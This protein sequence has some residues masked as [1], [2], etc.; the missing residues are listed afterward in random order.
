M[1]PFSVSNA[2]KHVALKFLVPVAALLGCVIL[3]MGGL[4]AR[5]QTNAVKEHAED[6]MSLTLASSQREMALTNELISQQVTTAVQLLRSRAAQ[7]YGRPSLKGETTLQGRRV[8]DLQLGGKH[9]TNANGLPDE[10]SGITGATATI[11]AA[12]G[13]DFVRVAT[14]IRKA[15]G[16][17]AIGTVLDPAG[18]AYAEVSQGR[19]F[20]GMVDILGKPYLTAYEPIK[21]EHGRVI[22]IFYAGFAMDA[23][24]Q[25]GD[26]VA[27]TN[28]LESG[29]IAVLDKKDRIIFK[30]K[31][32]SDEQ[33]RNV[34]GAGNNGDWVTKEQSF[35]PWSYRTVVS[36]P[37]SDLSTATRHIYLSTALFMIL[38][39]GALVAAMYW[40]IEFT[41]IRP[42]SAIIETMD[43]A[44]LSTTL[45][46]HQD[47]EIGNLC[48]A[49]N[50]FLAKIRGVLISVKDVSEKVYSSSGSLSSNSERLAKGAEVQNSEAMNV[51]AALEEMSV[52]VAMVNENCQKAA[53]Q[54]QETSSL[55]HKGGELVVSTMD[56]VR[57]MA[58]SIQKVTE[59]I[60]R[61]GNSSNEIGKAAAVIDGIAD[62]T[63][64]LA[65]NAAIEAARAG[66]QG[67]GFAVV[68][69]EVRKLAERT[70]LA[71]RE[72]GAMI[73]TVQKDT[74]A[75]VEA[76]SREQQE[77]EARSAQA[78][79]AR[80]ALEN[81]IC[82]TSE[83][84]SLVRQIA[85]AAGEHSRAT[86]N[87]TLHMQQITEMARQA[88][89]A[90][91]NTAMECTGLSTDAGELQGFVAQFYVG[92]QTEAQ[93]WKGLASTRD[94]A[95]H[96][97]Q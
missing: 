13:R 31:S 56:S 68:A 38:S 2:K 7:E 33:I 95:E 49:L 78:E 74:H 86:E 61:L 64:L 3:L 45:K 25:L 96:Q 24:R 92:E 80:K 30:T 72:I 82:S 58:A 67:R 85:N 20:Y 48:N 37:K 4:A 51:K 69:D 29:W 40:M 43:H 23:L 55:A 83:V 97:L 59:V 10:V 75:A 5:K 41:V 27:H 17:R 14:S 60:T 18:A 35:R 15:N 90:A 89:S 94:F 93:D 21:E 1:K 46:S 9:I 6:Q 54:V 32:A 12:S 70:G 81:I 52:N 26:A 71:T 63:N 8:G 84:E 77:I 11:F 28:I 66:E 47:D 76:M 19:P 53:M 50:R 39:I 62:Q 65:L 22:G 73:E 36:Y 88:A 44:D 42:I 57:E 79:S 34:L 16:E 87:V 91:K